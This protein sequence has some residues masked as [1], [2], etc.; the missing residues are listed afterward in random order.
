MS[1]R[2]QLIQ[3]MMQRRQGLGEPTS[4]YGNAGVVVPDFSSNP[5]SYQNLRKGI[6]RDAQD[7]EEG[8]LFAQDQMIDEMRELGIDQDELE[9]TIMSDYEPTA[10]DEILNAPFMGFMEQGPDLPKERPGEDMPLSV[11]M[12]N[13]NPALSVAGSTEPPLRVGMG[14]IDPR[15]TAATGLA[16]KNWMDHHKPENYD[17]IEEYQQ[18]ALA[19]GVVNPLYGNQTAQKI[20]DIYGVKTVP[21]KNNVAE[22][23]L[24]AAATKKREINKEA[25][26]KTLGYFGGSM[27]E[28]DNWHKGLDPERR[29]AVYDWETALVALQGGEGQ[30]QETL[31][32]YEKYNAAIETPDTVSDEGYF[33]GMDEFGMFDSSRDFL[34]EGPMFSQRDWDD[35]NAAEAEREKEIWDEFNAAEKERHAEIAAGNIPSNISE[36]EVAEFGLVGMP[37]P[38][39]ITMHDRENFGH[40]FAAAERMRGARPPAQSP[41]G[42]AVASINSEDIKN[43]YADPAVDAAPDGMFSQEAA[44]LSQIQNQVIAAQAPD[45]NSTS[46]TGEKKTRRRRRR[47]PGAGSQPQAPAPWASQPLFNPGAIPSS[48]LARRYHMRRIDRRAGTGRF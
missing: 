47:E 9:N 24:H 13:M 41:Q 26:E 7:F 35:F 46:S 38:E 10:K 27:E 36:E 48:D 15:L 28:Y 32:P 17:S 4:Q 44:P 30:G 5:H 45:A 8:S 34:Q 40:H 16:Q 3:R 19:D 43:W 25:F 33:S 22:R 42:S 2:E 6:L 29:K 21:D 31:K 11:G 23:A 14:D 20:R 1:P 18:A 39:D 12:G 37:S